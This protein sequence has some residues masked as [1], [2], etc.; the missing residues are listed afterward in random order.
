MIDDEITLQL[1]PFG[2]IDIQNVKNDLTSQG[3]SAKEYMMVSWCTLPDLLYE[4]DSR[5][6]V[7]LSF[8]LAPSSYGFVQRMVDQ[9]SDSRCK[10]VKFNIAS[11]RYNGCGDSDRLELFWEPSTDNVLCELASLDTGV[12]I[13]CDLK[14]NK[15]EGEV[16]FAFNILA[17]R[18]IKDGYGLK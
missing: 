6:L 11:D 2:I 3:V 10:Y 7:G 13:Y 17:L 14:E 9:V 8:L 5:K 18:E 15:I 12:W 1:M 4:G 16:P